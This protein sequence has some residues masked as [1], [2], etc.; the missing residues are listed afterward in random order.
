MTSELEVESV[1]GRLEM[2]GKVPVW[3]RPEKEHR[4]QCMYYSSEGKGIQ[5]SRRQGIPQSHTRDLLGETQASARVRSSGGL[6]R[7][8]VLYRVF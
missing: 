1:A 8:Q 3:L 7:K 2:R 6:N 5:A 4:H